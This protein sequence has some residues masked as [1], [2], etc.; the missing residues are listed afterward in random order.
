MHTHSLISLLYLKM[1]FCSSHRE[2]WEEMLS[3]SHETLILGYKMVICQRFHMSQPDTLKLQQSLSLRAGL[4]MSK[5]NSSTSFSF[6]HYRL[7]FLS[8]KRPCGLSGKTERCL[9]AAPLWALKHR[10]PL[11]SACQRVNPRLGWGLAQAG[12]RWLQVVCQGV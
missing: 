4:W 12:M 8:E 7:C 2:R 3:S 9:S 5:K 10:A 1:H 6:S 11:P